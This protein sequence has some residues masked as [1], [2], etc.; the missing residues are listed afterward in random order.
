M[1]TSIIPLKVGLLPACNHQQ[2]PFA[3]KMFTRDDDLGWKQSTAFK[4][5]FSIDVHIDFIGVWYVRINILTTLLLSQPRVYRDT[6]SSV[7]IIPHTLPFTSS[8]TA[9]RVF[10]HALSLDEHRARFRA[11]LYH[12]PSDADAARGTQPGDMPKSDTEY[13]TRVGIRQPQGNSKIGR[14]HV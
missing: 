2:V 8:N 11:N 12:H 1:L 3:Y 14:A 10:R 7:G 9:I 4:K 5:A 6:V 13:A